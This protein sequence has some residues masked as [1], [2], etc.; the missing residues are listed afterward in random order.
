MKSCSSRSARVRVDQV[1]PV[2]VRMHRE[3]LPHNFAQQTM[4]AVRC[5]NARTQQFAGVAGRDQRMTRAS[6]ALAALTIAAAL[7]AAFTFQSTHDAPV[8][9]VRLA[10][11]QP[12]PI[13][14]PNLEL[15]ATGALMLNDNFVNPI[16][17]EAEALIDTGRGMGEAMLSAL[18]TRPR[19]WS[20]R[21]NDMTSR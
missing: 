15:R 14:L 7:V 13:A 5:A 6:F 17:S 4:A 18:P 9:P 16:R 11:N 3:E 10:V 1:L 2:H 8:Q 21:L 20:D 19:A 12:K